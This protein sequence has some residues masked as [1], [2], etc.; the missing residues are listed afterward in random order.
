MCSG[1]SSF[2]KFELLGWYMMYGVKHLFTCYLPFVYLWWGVC[3]GFHASILISCL[4]SYYS[5]LKVLC[6]LW[7]SVIYRY[8]NIVICEYCEHFP[9]NLLILLTVSFTVQKNLT[10]IKAS[11]LILYKVL[12]KPKI[13]LSVIF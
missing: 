12:A 10:L 9:P 1:I 7:I 11:F 8:V 4:L 3:Y 2:F 6:I 5:I 13:S